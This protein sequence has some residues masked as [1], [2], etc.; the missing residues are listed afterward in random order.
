V[1]GCSDLFEV[2]FVGG[3]IGD[4]FPVTYTFPSLTIGYARSFSSVFRVVFSNISNH[5]YFLM[6]SL[7]Q[8]N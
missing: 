6:Y 1:S 8:S 2:D 5:L 3:T 7:Q 4:A